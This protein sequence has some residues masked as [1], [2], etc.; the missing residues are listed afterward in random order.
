MVECA[1]CKKRLVRNTDVMASHYGDK[2][3]ELFCSIDCLK[4]SMGKKVVIR[5]RR[6]GI[7]QTY[8]K[9]WKE[10]DIKRARMR[11]K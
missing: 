6:D 7:V 4:K 3:I 5:K 2:G 10:Q 9:E 1:Q 8:K 11:R